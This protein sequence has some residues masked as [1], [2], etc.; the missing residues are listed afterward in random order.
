MLS[1]VGSTQSGCLSL[2][3]F[4]PGGNKDDIITTTIQCNLKPDHKGMRESNF[5]GNDVKVIWKGG[6]ETADWIVD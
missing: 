1:A 6:A 4:A 5:D 2:L 3:R